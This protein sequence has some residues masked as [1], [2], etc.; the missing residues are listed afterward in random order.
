VVELDLRSAKAPR[1]RFQNALDKLLAEIQ[2]VLDPSAT[3]FPGLVDAAPLLP[4][5]APK[6]LLADSSYVFLFMM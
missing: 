1:D 3:T 4:D 2:A 6:P 5:D